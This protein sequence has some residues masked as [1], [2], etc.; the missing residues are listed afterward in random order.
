MRVV[1]GIH[2]GRILYRVEKP[3]TRETA[4]MVK[5]AVFNMLQIHSGVVLDLYAGSGAYGI[6]ALSR[7]ADFC[8]FVDM[9]KDAIQ[10]VIKNLKMLKIEDQ[11]KVFQHTDERFIKGLDESIKFDVIFLDPP[12]DDENYQEVISKLQ[13]HLNTGGYIVCE[14]KKQTEIYLEIQDLEK[15]KNKTY[16]IKRITIFQKK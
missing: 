3:T 6:E 12:Y 9:D 5:V 13:S 1:G 2:R 4:D 7:G 8:Y 15:I 10:T 16:G 11:A 14:S